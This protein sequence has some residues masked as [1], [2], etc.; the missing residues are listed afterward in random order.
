MGNFEV[1]TFDEARA[2]H[3]RGLALRSDGGQS[4]GASR[5]SPRS[6]IDLFGA[7]AAPCA[8]FRR[9][10]AA[11]RGAVPV[12]AERERRTHL[13]LLLELPATLLPTL[14]ILELVLVQRRRLLDAV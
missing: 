14:L 5:R 9:L 1:L 3:L 2:A 8:R 12:A 4:G 6:S 11:V 13:E 10:R 7:A